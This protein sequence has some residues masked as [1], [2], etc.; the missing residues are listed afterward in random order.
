MTDAKPTYTACLLAYIE[1]QAHQDG[2]SPKRQ[3]QFASYVRSFSKQWADENGGSRPEKKPFD[4]TLTWGKYKGKSIEKLAKDV[5]NHNYL[6]YVKE[7]GY[8]SEDVKDAILFH[9]PDE[10]FSDGE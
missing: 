7:S 4:G 1:A 10:V 8:A 3:R 6:R 2:V 5:A 9:L